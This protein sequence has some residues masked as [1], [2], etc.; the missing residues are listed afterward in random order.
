[1]RGLPIRRGGWKRPPART[2]PGIALQPP[3]LYNFAYPK[4]GFVKTNP[5]M[6]P[7]Q[8]IRAWNKEDLGRMTRFY[9]CKMDDKSPFLSVAKTLLS[10]AS[11]HPFPKGK[12]LVEN[13][14]PTVLA[15]FALLFD[16]KC[17]T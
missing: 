2:W 15:F 10:L 17:V 14:P 11:S 1:V 9:A 7:K 12:G 5:P 8:T 4:G 16:R 13:L 6:L 3:A